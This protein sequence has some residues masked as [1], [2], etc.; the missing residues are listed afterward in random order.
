VLTS[1]RGPQ[2]IHTSGGNP[3][4][5][6]ARKT[7]TP[8][9]SWNEK[10]NLYDGL[11]H[12]VDATKAVSISD[13]RWGIIEKAFH[14]S[15]Q[16]KSTIPESE[17]LYDFFMSRV[18]DVL[19]QKE[20]QK[21]LLGMAE[22]WGDYVGDPVQRQSLKFAWLEECCGGGEMCHIGMNNLGG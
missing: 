2:W 8:L 3:I 18:Q 5:D 14:H 11:G 1:P 7:N 9:H 12:L 4:L 16:N 22:M 15:I 6:I 17:S 13:L 19:P 21:L 10:I 20:D